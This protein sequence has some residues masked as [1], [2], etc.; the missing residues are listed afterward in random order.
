[1]LFLR[2]LSDVFPNEAHF[3][4]HLSDVLVLSGTY[5]CNKIIVLHRWKPGPYLHHICFFEGT[6]CIKM[7]TLPQNE[8]LCVL[9]TTL[10]D[11]ESPLSTAGNVFSS[12]KSVKSYKSIF[13]QF[14]G[15]KLAE[16]SFFPPCFLSNRLHIQACLTSWKS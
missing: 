7:F 8:I 4:R 11:A 12:P 15:F 13:I 1:M 2:R 6:L 5:I 9:E 10:S 14:N 16:K 3:S